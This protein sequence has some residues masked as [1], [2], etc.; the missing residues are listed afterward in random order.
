MAI[1][2]PNETELTR[3]EEEATEHLAEE[4]GK[5]S[6]DLDALSNQPELQSEGEEL[7]TSLRAAAASALQVVGAG[8]MVGGIYLGLSPRFYAVTA[9]LLGVGLAIFAAR[10]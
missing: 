10:I 3:L 8:V 2:T 5:L 4:A 7:Q 1:Q 9:G 6:A